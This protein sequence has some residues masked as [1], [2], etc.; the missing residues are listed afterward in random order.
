VRGPTR[1]GLQS[2]AEL[3]RSQAQP[4]PSAGSSRPRARCSQGTISKSACAD[5]RR[6][7]F[8]HAA[9]TSRRAR[10]RPATLPAG[11]RASRAPPRLHPGHL[12][13]LRRIPPSRPIRAN[14]SLA[15]E[16]HLQT[17]DSGAGLRAVRACRVTVSNVAGGVHHMRQTRRGPALEPRGPTGRFPASSPAGSDDARSWLMKRSRRRLERG[18]GPSRPQGSTGV[19]EV[20]L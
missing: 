20:R 9:F 10:L 15:T 18:Y 4:A 6:L 1:S 12:M 16:N 5:L 3:R 11:P 14:R 13:P 7:R 19:E 8:P 17:S 2:A